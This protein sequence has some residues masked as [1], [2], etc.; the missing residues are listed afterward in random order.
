VSAYLLAAALALAFVVVHVQLR[1]IRRR[2]AKSSKLSVTP[3]QR[4]RQVRLSIAA[5]WLFA[6]A[7]LAG[8]IAANRGFFWVTPL[9][10]GIVVLVLGRLL[11]PKP[12]PE[13][14]SE[15]PSQGK[16]KRDRE[17]SIWDEP[18]GGWGFDSERK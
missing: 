12:I 6:T 3:E 13:S 2:F 16:A 10:F 7:A 18:S 1:R 14:G 11:K 8:V 4:R 9:S 15:E 17:P 5:T